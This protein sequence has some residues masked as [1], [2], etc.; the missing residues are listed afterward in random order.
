MKIFSVSGR[1]RICG[2]IGDPIAHTM[3]PAMHNAAFREMGLDY[4]FVAFKVKSEDL[5]P[6][7]GGVKAL[8]MRGLCV[9]IPHK[10]AVIPFL[11]EID[12]LANHIGAVNTI[13]NQNGFLKGYNTDAS[14]FLEA[15]LARGVDPA[16]KKAVVLGAGGA[17]RAI[18]FILAERK[19]D[20]VVLNRASGLGRAATLASRIS[21]LSK[22][23]V[24]VLE[25]NET[26]LRS[27]IRNADILVNATSVGMNPSAGETPVPGELLK[28]GLVVYDIVYNPLQTRL[29][30]EAEEA[31]AATIGGLEML[32]WQGVSAFELW[33]GLKPPADVMRRAARQSLG[34]HEE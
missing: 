34:A 21:Q 17:S 31:G 10:V 26:N 12:P 16:G 19:T 20:L 1:T 32:V 27:E 33:T 13:V 28:P 9:T 22:Q 25:L 4:M 23:K 15:L 2:I 5:Q 11:D 24:K 7:V 6:A 29:L 8:D 30:S 14:G 18:C 3:S